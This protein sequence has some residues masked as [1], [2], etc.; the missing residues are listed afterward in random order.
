MIICH[1]YPNLV[2]VHSNETHNKEWTNY[3]SKVVNKISL[4]T[5]IHKNMMKRYW[6]VL[7]PTEKEMTKS[8][9]TYMQF[10][11]STHLALSCLSFFNPSPPLKKKKNNNNKKVNYILVGLETFQYILVYMQNY[12]GQIW[13]TKFSLVQRKPK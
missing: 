6:K 3:T 11:Y 8:H 5:I 7:N 13:F 2:Q 12:L 1:V 4:L 9:E 10:H